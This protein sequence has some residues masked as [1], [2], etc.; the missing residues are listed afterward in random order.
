[1]YKKFSEVPNDKASI[2]SNVIERN[3]V[4]IS[5]NRITCITIVN[6]INID[7]SDCSFNNCIID[8]ACFIFARR[9]PDIDGYK[10]Y[11]KKLYLA[12]ADYA[13]YFIKNGVATRVIIAL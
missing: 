7:N 13:L 5:L 8:V 3:H 9:L 10:I 11:Y 1:M 2:I 4:N 12:H 6:N